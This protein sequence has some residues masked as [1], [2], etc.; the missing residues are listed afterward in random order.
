MPYSILAGKENMFFTQ[1]NFYLQGTLND[2]NEQ[3]IFS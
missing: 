2:I 3:D 1:E